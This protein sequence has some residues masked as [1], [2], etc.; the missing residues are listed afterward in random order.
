MRSQKIWFILL[1]TIIIDHPTYASDAQIDKVQVSGTLPSVLNQNYND[2]TI[3]A[4]ASAIEYLTT[5]KNSSHQSPLYP[6]KISRSGLYTLAKYSAFSGINDWKKNVYT[7]W[8]PDF[9]VSIGEALI[10][11][12]KYGCFP[13]NSFKLEDGYFVNGWPYAE[14]QTPVPPEML[15]IASDTSFDGITPSVKPLLLQ[16]SILRKTELCDHQNPYAKVKKHLFYT[17]IERPKTFAPDFYKHLKDQTQNDNPLV[18]GISATQDF[19]GARGDSVIQGNGALA[20]DMHVILVLGIAW[21][22]H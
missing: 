9:G 12:N 21:R 13:E 10:T 2:C 19:V 18:I 6:L 15:H 16:G 14:Q 3:N 4:I 8:R 20:R 1:L 5:P 11:L 17:P 22:L 7:A